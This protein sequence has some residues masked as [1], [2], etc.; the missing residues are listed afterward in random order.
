MRQPHVVIVTATTLEYQAAKQVEAGAW[1]GSRWEEE[2][3]PNGLPVAF[4]TFRGKEGKP[5]R[6]AVAQ[7]GGMAGVA[8]VNALLPLVEKY[9]PRCV[10]MCGVCAGHPK[11]TN[12][13]DVIAADRLFFHDTGKRE[14]GGVKQDIQ[15]YNLREDW[16]VAIEH[17]GFPSRFRN[18]EWWKKRPVPYEWQGNWALA[19]LHQGVT[20][21]ASHPE[22]G[23]RCPQWEKVIESLWEAG[24]VQHG[25][26][27]LTDTGRKHIGSVLIK[28]RNRFPDL[29]PAGTVLP[30]RVHVAPMGSGNQVI[31]DARVWDS[32]TEP[33]RKTLGLEMEAAA[34]GA[35]AHAQRDKKLEAVVMKGVMD[36]ANHGRDDHFKEF[37]ARASAECL[38]AF[39]REQLDVEVIPGDDDLLVPGTG[40][41]PEDPPPSA[42][43]NA[44]YEVV[45]FHEQGRESILTEL[46][47]WSEG[48][49]PIAVRLIHAE[50]GVGKTRLAIEWIRRR[51]A[52]GWAAGFLG[53]EVPEDWFERLWALGQPVLAVL[54]YAESRSSLQKELLRV[55]RYA[56]QEGSGKLRQVRLLLLA[57][58]AGD[59]WQSLRQSD[60]ALRE[61]LGEPHQLKPL[62]T[63]VEEREK[64]FH[65][66]AERF[67]RAK[68]KTYQPRT[69]VQWGDA[70]FERVLYLHMAALATV[71]GLEF[72][73]H[74]LMDRVL[75]HEERFWEARAGLEGVA[76]DF[77]RSK[78]R[79]VVAA[80]TLRGGFGDFDTAVRVAESLF[81]E[82]T[83]SADGRVLL[84]LLQ[85][86]YQRQE[87]GGSVYLPALEPDLLGEGMVLRVAS[88][89]QAEERPPADWIERVFPAGEGAG[90]V[91]TGF[92]VLGRASAARAD[93]VR[94]WIERLL[95]AS[96]HER[97]RLALEAAKA[98]GLRTAFSV[99]GDV[100]AEQLEM[101]GDARLAREL[102]AAGILYKAVSLRRVAEWV[103]RTLLSELKVSKDERVLA[104]RARHQNNLGASLSRLGRREEALKATLEAVELRRA[105][106][107]GNPDAFQPNLAGSLNNLGV[108]LSA[109]GRREDALKATQEAVKVFQALSE[110]NPD[111]FQPD[112]A[113]SL[114]NLGNSLSE[115][116]RRE[117]ALEATQEAV[118]VYR[119]L[120]ERNPDAFQP[121]LA[122]SL[123]NLGIRFS[124][125]GRQED[126]LKATQ[127]AVELRRALSKRNPDAFQLDLAMSLDNLGNR[128]SG[129]GRSEEALKA[130]QEAVKMY[131]ALSERNP[132]TFQPELAGSLN[133]L[134]LRLGR[135][136]RRE[137]ALAAFEGALDMIWPL[138]KRLP[139]AFMRNT[140]FMI[141]NLLQTHESLQRPLPPILMERIEEFM[142]LSGLNRQSG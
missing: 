102:E 42:L 33:M 137:E 99:L 98:V 58:N 126:A 108:M 134:G 72:E 49:A 81:R 14:P 16:K 8:T 21:P 9:Q 51:R 56:Q 31:E 1:E 20:D 100:L 65:E 109:L 12:L 6:V 38:L 17:L 30:F 136:G 32:I 53:K 117:D 34:I 104:E 89:K 122:M 25:T 74:T 44:R 130:T 80:A 116:G 112:F 128:L 124:K 86:T 113:M 59:W 4:R 107:E 83:L 120:S 22:C 93:G 62:A 43:L 95:G 110:R 105:L 57:R 41:L 85:R 24:H 77:E 18:E 79:Q 119:L 19:M 135:L 111:A 140:E 118:K 142:R 125:L 45:P 114:N 138:F 75:D 76:R 106:S 46:D 23:E 121:D 132:D 61:W 90:A 15:T 50:G 131:R 92:E 68:G 47:R 11:K 39:L 7:A 52:Q 71:E 94:P 133:N 2:P 48:G 91:G 10:A 54:D 82:G 28:H 87:A 115:L 35:V 70:Q 55:L 36:F 103:S 5:L 73:A 84:W 26:L 127:E 129:L 29:T 88:P 97:A 101:Q 96:L 139:P 69:A 3:G 40:L 141:K 63:R 60:E 67:A 78:A 64:V 13:G 27:T 123:N 37:A 66:A